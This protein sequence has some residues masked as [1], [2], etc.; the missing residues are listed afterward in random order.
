[1][2]FIRSPNSIS[3]RFGKLRRRCSL[4]FEKKPIGSG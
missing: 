3:F 4:Y 2:G 1:M